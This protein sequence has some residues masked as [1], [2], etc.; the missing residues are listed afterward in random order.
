M[1]GLQDIEILEEIGRR[2]KS[3]PLVLEDILNTDQR[4]KV[5]DYGDYTL[6]L[7]QGFS[8]T[9]RAPGNRIATRSAWWSATT[10]CSAFRNGRPANSGIT[11]TPAGQQGPGAQVGADYLVI[12]CST[13][14]S[15]T[16]SSYLEHLSERTEQLESELLKSRRQHW[17]ASTH[18]KMDTMVIRRAL[19]PLREVLNML[20]GEAS[21]FRQETL[22]YLRDVYDPPCT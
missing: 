1:H 2:F 19:W 21:L 12:R 13:P 3:H 20:H 11:R 15:I 10:S 4:P 17:P 14:S 18:R 8:N 9:T 5:E 22:V 7:S 16:I 6:S